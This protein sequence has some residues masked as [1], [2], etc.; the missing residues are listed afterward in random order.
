MQSELKPCPFCG[1]DTAEVVGEVGF[2][3]WCGDNDCG[4][5]GPIASTEA[6]AIAAWNSR[7]LPTPPDTA[8]LLAT[9]AKA[10]P[11][12]WYQPDGANGHIWNNDAEKGEGYT[13]DRVIF[14][15]PMQPGWAKDRKPDEWYSENERN[16][17]A[18]A[19]SVNFVRDE[20]PALIAE[21]EGLRE[22]LRAHEIKAANGDVI[23]LADELETAAGTLDCFRDADKENSPNGLQ[24]CIDNDGHAYQSE[25]MAGLMD[26]ALFSSRNL[27]KWAATIRAAIGGTA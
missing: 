9:V 25:F 2:L 26:H 19:A 18:A 10:T 24:D 3:V 13:P 23:G 1:R 14:E 4:T 5:A 17:A 20:L 11:G 15:G 7:A 21:R 12:E 8:A 6:Q 27:R 16:L 22:A